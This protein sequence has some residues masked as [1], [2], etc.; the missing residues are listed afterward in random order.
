MH[1]FYGVFTPFSRKQGDPCP[2]GRRRSRAYHRGSDL[3][4]RSLRPLPPRS[5]RVPHGPVVEAPSAKPGPSDAQGTWPLINTAY[6]ITC[7]HLAR[8]PQGKTP[9]RA[10]RNGRCRAPAPALPPAPRPPAATRSVLGASRKG[11][12]TTDGGTVVTPRSVSR[13][14]PVSSIVRTTRTPRPHPS[15]RSTVGSAATPTASR[16]SPAGASNRLAYGDR[17]PPA[18][19][20]R[21]RRALGRTG[22]SRSLVPGGPTDRT[23]PFH[24]GMARGIGGSGRTVARLMS[25]CVRFLPK[26]V[27]AHDLL[28]P[29]PATPASKN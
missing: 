16:A 20:S 6:V 18:E 9:T 22:W 26:D 27:C 14:S 8:A 4:R 10:A 1:L 28:C 5:P 13:L 25:K 3:P 17:A 12:A 21:P 29:G 15:N 19:V 2:V 11:R 24:I 23:A 7:E